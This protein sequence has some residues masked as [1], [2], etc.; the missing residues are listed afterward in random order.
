VVLIAAIPSKVANAKADVA[1]AAG[2]QKSAAKNVSNAA[3]NR[4][5][6]FSI[7]DPLTLRWIACVF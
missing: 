7:A 5:A 3:V 1:N 4:T 6:D 2:A